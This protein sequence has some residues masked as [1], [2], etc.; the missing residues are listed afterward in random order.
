MPVESSSVQTMPA[1]RHSI[2]AYI[3]VKDCPELLD[4]WLSRMTW[5]DEILV[6][7]ASLGD[8]IALLINERYP[9]VRRVAD[10]TSDHRVRFDRHVH[11]LTSDYV[12]GLDADELVP[13]EAALEIQ[14]A[15]R[16]PC[17][18][19]GFLVP[20]IS[21]VFGECIGAGTTQL[22]LFRRDRYRW[23]MR[24]PHEMPAVEGPIGTLTQ[25]YEHHNSPSL[26]LVPIKHFRYEAAH[27]AQMSD[28][29]L[30]RRALDTKSQWRLVLSALG[31]LARINIR[32]LRTLWGARRLG[33]VGLWLAYGQAF[34]VIAHHVTPT[35]ERRMRA[36][37]ISRDRQGYL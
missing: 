10:R 14:R 20:S 25:P 21:Y 8:E 16:R 9:R 17:P 6:A 32:F 22:R 35:E 28:D 3:G 30:T 23:P 5:A 4:V 12:I 19:N 1:E 31:E 2:A 29:E 34:Q 7:D 27:A 37:I 36:G 13:P 18:Y 11:E 26:A 15:L 24:S 33:F